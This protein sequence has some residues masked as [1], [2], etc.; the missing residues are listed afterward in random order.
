MRFLLD[1]PACFL[2]SLL[3]LAVC[4]VGV[5]PAQTFQ[6]QQQQLQ[7]QQQRAYEEQQR[8]NQQYQAQ[9]QQQR[10]LDQQRQDTQRMLENSR[11]ET[12]RMNESLRQSQQNFQ[13]QMDESSRRQ[14]EW[15][16]QFNED[17]ER[18][19]QRMYNDSV[20]W[21]QSLQQRRSQGLGGSNDG[22]S[23]WERAWAARSAQQHQAW[24]QHS[25]AEQDRWDAAARA[26]VSRTD[27]AYAQRRKSDRVLNLLEQ[28]R[29]ARGTSEVR[30]RIRQAAERARRVRDRA[31]Q[32][33]DQRNEEALHR[34]NKA[35]EA[36]QTGHSTSREQASNRQKS[37]LFRAVMAGSVR[38]AHHDQQSLFSLAPFRR[39]DYEET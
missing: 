15:N 22:G 32:A 26:I 35:R 2:L 1:R 11:R 39:E 7:Q 4:L 33:L 24:N 23:P 31:R 30:T 5:A 9:Q 28:R 36:R 14:Q 3:V 17:L 12:E 34:L 21:Q 6:Q 8:R 19:R 38:A 25:H 16:R 20:R 29:A 18:Q 37:V 10:A 13:R 27:E